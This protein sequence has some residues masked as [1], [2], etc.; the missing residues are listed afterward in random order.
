MQPVLVALGIGQ[1]LVRRGEDGARVGHRLVQE[2]A[3]R[4]RCPGRSAR[5]CCAGS[6]AACCVAAGG[7]R[8]AQLRRE[9]ATNRPTAP[10]PRGSAPPPEQGGQV[11]ARPQAVHVG[12]AAAGLAAEQHPHERR[13]GRGC[14]SRRA[15]LGDAVAEGLAGR[16]PAGRRSGS[17][18]RD[19]GAAAAIAT[20]HAARWQGSVHDRLGFAAQRFG[21]V[22][23]PPLRADGKRAPRRHSRRAC[24]WMSPI[25]LLGHE[26]VA[27]EHPERR[28][29]RSAAGARGRGSCAGAARRPGPR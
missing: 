15:R 4:S 10:A 20:R 13:V 14:G 24:Q 11:R 27:D 2:R 29:G 7:R 26:R 12:L 23:V 19:P 5:R 28:S 21:V 9:R 3:G 25:V 6:G 1:R 16:R 18:T 8:S 17:P 22:I